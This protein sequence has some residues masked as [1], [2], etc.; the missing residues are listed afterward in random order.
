MEI[1]CDRSGPILESK[2]MHAIFLKKG[3]KGK[4]YESLGK[5]VKFENILKKGRW[6]RAIIV[7]TELLE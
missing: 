3:K 1:K 2:D 4:I 5:N 7:P 6:L